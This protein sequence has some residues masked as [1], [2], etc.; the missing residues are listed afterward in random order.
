MDDGSAR[1]PVRVTIFNQTYSL[2]ASDEPG[3]VEELAHSVDQLMHEV[4][5]KAGN[6]DTA[7]T[8]VLTCLHLADQKR[9][10]EKEIEQ[11][12]QRVED[13]ARQF[14]IRLD[15]ALTGSAGEGR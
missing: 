6:V 1:K 12:K 13:K 9:N 5:V 7:R 4:A 8:A 2:I 15:E 11:L 3:Q 10:L 14:S